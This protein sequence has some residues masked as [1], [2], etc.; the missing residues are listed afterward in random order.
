M[1]RLILLFPLLLLTACSPKPTSVVDRYLKDIQSGNTTDQTK[2]ECVHGKDADKSLIQ[3]APAWTIVGEQQRSKP[4]YSYHVVTVKIG[5]DTFHVR[6]WKTDD[7]YNQQIEGDKEAQS[8]GL[9][10]DFLTPDRSFF[11]P[12]DYCVSV[13]L[14]P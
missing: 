11:S 6:V 7:I 10:L 2:L 3:S 8:T 14:E 4:P 5:D 1:K 13:E 9:K 12:E